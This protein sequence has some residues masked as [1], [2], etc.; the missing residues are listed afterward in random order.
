MTNSRKLFNILFVL[1]PLVLFVVFVSYKFDVVNKLSFTADDLSLSIKYSYTSDPNINS[2]NVISNLDQFIPSQLNGAKINLGQQHNWY[3]LELDNN[4]NSD[5]DIV[6]LLD[7]P[8]IDEINVFEVLNGELHT[9][10]QFGDTRLTNDLE[11]IAIPHFDIKLKP[12]QKIQLLIETKTTGIPNLPIAFFTPN[13]FVSYKDTLYLI[14]GA[15]T[16]VV[17]LMSVYNLILYLGASKIIY[18]LYIGYISSFL[19]L[20]GHVHGFLIYLIP[21]W[22]FSFVATNILVVNFVISFFTIRFCYSFL[23]YDEE[24]ELRLSK[25]S[26]WYANLVLALGVVSLFIVEYKIAPIFFLVQL[27]LYVLAVLLIGRKI[28][29]G[30]K[31]ARFYIISWYPLFIGAVISPLL[32][33]GMIEYNFWT[34]HA[35]LL[36]VLFEMALI[37]M[38]LAEQLKE[39]EDRRIY[40]ILHD[41]RFGIANGSM[42]E[43]VSHDTRQ[44][45]SIV[46]IKIYKYQSIIPYLTD[47][48]QKTLLFG[49]IKQIQ[50]FLEQ[51]LMLI[52]IEQN[53]QFKKTSL[54]RDGILAFGVT[55]NDKRLIL[56]VLRKFSLQ[57]PLNFNKGDLSISFTCHAGVAKHNPKSIDIKE[58]VNKAIL[59]I[60]TADNRGML[61]GFYEDDSE[62]LSKR[63]IT[64]AA[65]LQAAIA[66]DEIELYHQPQLDITTNTVVG[67]EVLLRWQHKELGFIPPDEF[68]LMAEQTGVIHKLSQWV[69]EQSCK[70]LVQLFEHNYN[71]IKLSV[72]ISVHDV[73]DDAFIT[74]LV[75][76]L[77]KYQLS[78]DFFVLELTET[79]LVTDASKFTKNILEIKELGFSLAIDDF[80]TGYSSL[81]YVSKHPF[82]ELKIDRDFIMFIEQSDKDKTIVS[83]TLTLAKSLSLASVA[84]GVESKMSLQI[85][86]SLGCDLAQGYFIAKPMPFNQ[87]LDWLVK[88]KGV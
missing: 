53:V 28:R 38:A 12:Q 22:L 30:E 62:Q 72:N 84:E 57:Q 54:I 2:S 69:F 82:D 5:R 15:L 81:T 42:M 79:A 45:L 63:K 17:I 19:L 32:L 14:W 59:A 8:M 9:L 40:Q 39:S 64:L 56:D 11:Y 44:N 77:N 58:T 80:G 23:K 88:F 47:E 60:D 36:G 85:L 20:L 31:W 29:K 13:D 33:N 49:F 26:I 1:I 83:A 52:D 24:A 43:V 27:G 48:N 75:R 50:S 4:Y 46:V 67:S 66:K 7:A 37:S 21:T 3:F 55:S 70:H 25:F 65:D 10:H 71:R 74:F 61:Y 78:A 68:V 87:Y 41:T 6:T 34:R 73:M 86:S 18:L 16:G 35:L 51:E 76:T